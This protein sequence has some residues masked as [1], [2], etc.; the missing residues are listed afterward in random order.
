MLKRSDETSFKNSIIFNPINDDLTTKNYIA[1]ARCILGVET[2]KG[3]KYL[4]IS[5]V[6]K[7]YGLY[8]ANENK[9]KPSKYPRKVIATNIESG[10]I[11]ELESVRQ[12]SELFNYKIETMRTYVDSP[13]MANRVWKLTYKQE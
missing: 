4:D 5:K 13:K 10:E 2:N 6:C 12:A 11:I 3:R 9:K 1:L 7:A 8:E